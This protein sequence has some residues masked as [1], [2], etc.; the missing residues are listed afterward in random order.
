LKST[1]RKS[2]ISKGSQKIHTAVAF[3]SPLT[4]SY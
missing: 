2:A 1:D 4:G 3:V